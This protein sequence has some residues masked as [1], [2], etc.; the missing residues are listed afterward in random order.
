MQEYK[1]EFP[2]YDDPE[3]KSSDQYSKFVI[4]ALCGDGNNDKEK[5]N[6]IINH[7]SKATTI[8]KSKTK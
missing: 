6:R 4:E 5:E 2:D 8:I 1:K 7:I 3:S